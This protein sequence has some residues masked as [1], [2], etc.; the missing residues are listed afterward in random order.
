M[1]GAAWL[2][3]ASNDNKHWEYVKSNVK[4]LPGSF[5]EFG[6]DSKDA[7][8]SVLVSGVSCSSLYIY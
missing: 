3:K 6:W 5:T 4:N 1:W 7:G 2:Y 8:I